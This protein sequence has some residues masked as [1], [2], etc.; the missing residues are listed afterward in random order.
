MANEQ[1]TRRAVVTGAGSGIGR[2]V[3]LRLARAGNRVAVI[4]IDEPTAR[5]VAQQIE[6][7]GGTALAITASV[8]NADEVEDAMARVDDAWGGLDVLVNNAGVTANRPTLELSHEDW[9]RVMDINLNGV[10][11]FAQEAGRRMTA[12]GSGSIINI[13]SIYSVVAA[14]N[15]L[16]YCA[17]KAAVAHM[18]RALA[19]EWAA[20]GVRVNA[21]APGYV[22]TPS[23]EELVGL[24]KIDLPALEGR[25]PMGR[26][27]RPEE[28]ADA[29]HFLASAEASYVTGQI[30]GVD[31]GWAAYGYI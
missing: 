27:A 16:A 5:A 4:D 7:L 10:F 8:A 21:I 17:T 14:P 12:Q 29:V 20:S 18:T 31:G 2:A 11:Y 1:D 3:A 25:T 19:I 24:G 15:R 23:T 30:L 28:I 13:G 6:Q 26:L 22:E 9:R